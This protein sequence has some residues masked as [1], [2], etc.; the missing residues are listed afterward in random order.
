MV[1][2]RYSLICSEQ[3]YINNYAQFWYVKKI[4]IK[5]PTFPFISILLGMEEMS[6]LMNC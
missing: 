4:E 3:W 6:L 5:T 2:S 1:K